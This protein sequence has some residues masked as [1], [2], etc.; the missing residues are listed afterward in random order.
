MV[1]AAITFK[2]R[3]S[4]QRVSHKS[5][6]CARA[7][8]GGFIAAGSAWKRVRHLHE[9]SV[10]LVGYFEKARGTF[11]REI[12]MSKKVKFETYLSPNIP[13]L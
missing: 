10:T 2:T 3:I 7:Q 4:F 12:N 11:I 13:R 8:K 6:A 5:I 1:S 9:V